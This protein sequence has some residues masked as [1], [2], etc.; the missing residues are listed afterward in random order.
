M[1]ILKELRQLQDFGPTGIY[2]LLRMTKLEAAHCTCACEAKIVRL[3]IG[4]GLG[5][6]NE[7]KKKQQQQR[8]QPFKFFSRK[9]KQSI[10]QTNKNLSPETFNDFQYT[11]HRESSTS[12][13]ERY[14]L[15][16]RLLQWPTL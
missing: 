12:L 4:K 16:N 5:L 13:V 1:R 7:L 10:N 14:I 3:D 6:L 11:V 9:K 15:A 2:A 8:S